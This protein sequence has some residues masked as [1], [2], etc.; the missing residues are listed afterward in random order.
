MGAIQCGLSLA[1]FLAAF[2]AAEAARNRLVSSSSSLSFNSSSCWF[3][4]AAFEELCFLVFLDCARSRED[5]EKVRVC[6]ATKFGLVRVTR[7]LDRIPAFWCLERHLNNIWMTCTKNASLPSGSFSGFDVAHP[8]HNPVAE[9]MVQTDKLPT[10]TNLDRIP[11]SYWNNLM[12]LTKQ[13]RVTIF[14]RVFSY[15]FSPDRE[16]H[17]FASFSEAIESGLWQAYR[18]RSSCCLR[19]TRQK[20]TPTS[21]PISRN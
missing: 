13:N 3:S 18:Y 6:K 11:M 17:C 4:S 16:A 15:S 9:M 14:L 5:I 20:V 8:S 2:S 12:K 10:S 19:S 21:L 7:C 1:T